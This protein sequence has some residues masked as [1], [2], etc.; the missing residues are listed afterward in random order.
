[1]LLTIDKTIL[2][3]IADQNPSTA[4]PGTILVTSK[5]IRAF[6]TKLKSPKVSIL[7]GNVKR[8]IKGFIKRLM[9]PKTIPTNTAVQK[10][11]TCTPGKRYALITIARPLIRKLSIK[12]IKL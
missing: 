6:I 11:L 1:M 8:T 4:N 10:P 5:I 9:I 12:L 3:N 2:K 7:I